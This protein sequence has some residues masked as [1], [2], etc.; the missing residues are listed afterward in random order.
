MPDDMELSIDY[1]P[2]GRNGK[3]TVTAR[4]NGEVV[5]V[6]SID[7]TKGMARASFAATV[8]NGRDGI[9]VEAV[10]AELLKAAADLDEGG[11]KRPSQATRLGGR[12]R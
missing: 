9:P 6:E 2:S 5:A 11:Q 10:E 1:A 12:S 7:L 4:V 3:A 8:A